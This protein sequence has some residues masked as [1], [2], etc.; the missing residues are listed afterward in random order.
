MHNITIHSINQSQSDEFIMII[1]TYLLI[2]ILQNCYNKIIF[3][4]QHFKIFSVKRICHVTF[5]CLSIIFVHVRV[6]MSSRQIRYFSWQC[7]FILSILCVLYEVGLEIPIPCLSRS[8]NSWN[9]CFYRPQ[10]KKLRISLRFEV[11]LLIYRKCMNIL[12]DVGL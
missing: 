7:P 3:P 12:I 5:I 4:T 9:S 2:H 1:H 8:D 11:L 10:L 6:K